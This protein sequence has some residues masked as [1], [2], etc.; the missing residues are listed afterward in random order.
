MKEISAD[1][2]LSML[3]TN[4][5]VRVT[6]IVHMK[7]SGAE[8]RKIMSVSGHRNIQSLEA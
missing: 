4:H 8:D 3:Y 2:N 7:A 6:S 1:A 5:C